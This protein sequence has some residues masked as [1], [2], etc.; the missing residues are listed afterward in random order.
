[1]I[2]RENALFSSDMPGSYGGTDLWKGNCK[3]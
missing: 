2:E 1:M 3:F